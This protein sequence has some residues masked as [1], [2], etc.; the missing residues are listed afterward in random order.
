MPTLQKTAAEVILVDG[1]KSEMVQLLKRDRVVGRIPGWEVGSTMERLRLLPFVG[2][3][4]LNQ[5]C[6]ATCAAEGS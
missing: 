2:L 4:D 6:G 1:D 5:A 3:R